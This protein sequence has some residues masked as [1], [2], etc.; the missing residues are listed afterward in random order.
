MVSI[1]VLAGG[2]S[3]RMGQDKAFLE[4]G[5]KP[6]I[7]RVL[8][9]V[10]PLT[11]D[12]FIS[13]NTSD[14]YQQYGLRMVNDIYPDKAALG[15]L[16]TAIHEARHPHV[17]VVACDMPF[18]NADLLQYLINLAD[19]ADVVAPV[20]NPPQPETMHAVYSKAC[21]APIEARLLKNRL[22][23]IG[24][25]DEVTV[26]Y[27]ER[28]AIEKFDPHLYAFVNMNTP[29]EWEQVQKIARQISS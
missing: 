3:K 28:P 25:F 20:I 26:R 1:A 4:V 29:E 13:T 6:V 8:E 11:D 2:Q 27:I 21:L 5:G 22:K 24:F 19:S 17:L 23:I 15:G 18:L 7:E 16:F 12:V 10:Q 9:C 14:R